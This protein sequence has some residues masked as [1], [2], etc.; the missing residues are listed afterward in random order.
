LYTGCETVFQ[1]ETGASETYQLPDFLVDTR[2]PEVVI[3]AQ[4]KENVETNSP[5]VTVT[6]S[7]ISVLQFTGACAVKEYSLLKG[8]NSFEMLGLPD[9]EYSDC[10]FYTIDVVGN[11]SAVVGLNAFSIDTISPTLTVLNRLP[12]YTNATSATANFRVNEKSNVSFEQQ[13]AG[14]GSQNIETGDFSISFSE[15]ED[16]DYDRCIAVIRDLAGNQ[17]RVNV[18]VFTIDSVSPV[19]SET[20]RATEKSNN[21]INSIIFNVNESGRFTSSG[22]CSVPEEIVLTGER[23]VEVTLAE[24][25]EVAPDTC[26]IN[27]TDRAGNTLN[28]ITYS[29]FSVDVIDPTLSLITGVGLVTKTLLPKLT[30]T[31]NEVGSIES[32]VDCPPVISSLAITFGENDVQF[33]TVENINYVGCDLR[34]KDQ[35]GN[36]SEW[37]AL[38]EFSSD[39]TKPILTITKDLGTII[40]SGPVAVELSTTEEGQL[41]V[42]GACSTD[43]LN[44]IKGNNSVSLHA[45][46][47]GQYFGCKFYITD[48]AGNQSEKVSI[49][50]FQVV[51][52]PIE[53]MAWKNSQGSLIETNRAYPGYTLHRSREQGCNIAIINSCD[54]GQSSD[55]DGSTINDT[56]FAFYHSAFTTIETDGGIKSKETWLTA[57]VGAYIAQDSMTIAF[58][59][60]LF[61][62]GSNSSTSTSYSIDGKSWAVSPIDRAFG[63]K[64]GAQVVKFKGK[65]WI[66]GGGNVSELT[67]EVWSSL[68]GFSWALETEIETREN[69]QTVKM[70]GRK[71]H[72]VVV[73]QDKIWLIGGENKYDDLKADV[74][75]SSDGRN[76]TRQTSFAP[77]GRR[78]NHQAVVHNNK[79]YVLGGKS[80]VSQQH[81]GTWTFNGVAWNQESTE[82]AF[83]PR[84]GMDI[85][86]FNGKW[87][88]IGGYRI[89]G[90]P[91]GEQK[92]IWQSDDLIQ[93]IKVVDDFGIEGATHQQL[94]KFDDKLWLTGEDELRSSADGIAWEY[95]V[96]HQ[97]IYSP[98]NG[99]A[100]VNFNG[101]SWVF[102][103][104]DG[105]LR[106]DIYRSADGYTWEKIKENAEFSSRYG[107]NVVEYKNRLWLVGGNTNSELK[108]DIWVSDDGISWSL[109]DSSAPFSAR[110]GHMLVSTPD[111]IFLMGGDDDASYWGLKDVW[112]TS[113]GVDWELVTNSAAY[114]QNFHPDATFFN[115]KLVIANGSTIYT[116]TPE[117]PSNWSSSNG[118][119]QGNYHNELVALD[120]ELFVHTYN[121]YM[122]S[123]SDLE[124]WNQHVDTTGTRGIQNYKLVA[125][126]GSIW[127]IGGRIGT[128]S[129]FLSG[130]HRF[131]PTDGWRQLFRRTAS[132]K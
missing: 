106:N 114:I 129:S 19:V 36:F 59:E 61:L 9:G 81:D 113:N 101:Y 123:S 52:S 43:V 37:L 116:A 92:D 115:G 85:E 121:G 57:G 26:S 12:P 112:K 73:F 42:T 67:A 110:E 51:P 2:I 3:N 39:V 56:S 1:P 31:A 126:E 50:A 80:D 25:G 49:P 53:L 108:N 64:K 20:T 40:E 10:A 66:I 14:I 99:H 91:A 109:S 94:V 21:L 30:V 100:T 38:A 74:W 47:I 65:L 23:S 124:N 82:N 45:L 117:E 128:Q 89:A 32:G 87:T 6:V 22:N 27:F 93:W 86:F 8:E 103:G 77:I 55:L 90:Y 11:R 76:W 95:A 13:C 15:L 58:D 71:G 69:G 104:F 29:A 120:G 41:F 35:Y 132:F 7:E 46:N 18:G 131:E 83:G 122:Y 4:P 54:F 98:R 62:Y 130:I 60:K 105:Q 75:S 16:A 34:V 107:H 88:L 72:Q 79:I 118:P 68:D 84:F 5:V 97:G 78:T 70:H 17:T 28:N 63:Q 102:G 96:E 44:L 24:G 33:Q 119:V 48:T 111:A 125:R 127:M